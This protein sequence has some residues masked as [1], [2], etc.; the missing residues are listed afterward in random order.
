MRIAY[1]LIFKQLHSNRPFS[2]PEKGSEMVSYPI[3]RK[4]RIN[5]KSDWV[6]VSDLQLVRLCLKNTRPAWEEFF[7]RFIPVIKNAIKN[8]LKERGRRDLSDDQDV[9][10]NIYEK[11]V[12]K[13]YKHA[14][15]KKCKKPS[16]IRQWLKT[17]AANQTLDWLKEKSRKKRLHKIN[18]KN[19]SYPYLNR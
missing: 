18:S 5:E 19:P 4:N 13:L 1:D 9:V 3:K 7:R 12:V 15:L 11:I 2:I 6:N 8:K 10:A 16:G 17:V 14:A